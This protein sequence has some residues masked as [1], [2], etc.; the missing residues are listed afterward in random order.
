MWLTAAKLR[1][2]TAVEGLCKLTKEC[3]V[4]GI[5]LERDPAGCL[6][7]QRLVACKPWLDKCHAVIAELEASFAV[8][9]FQMHLAARV[10][11]TTSALVLRAMMRRRTAALS[12]KC[13]QLW[14]GYKHHSWLPRWKTYASQRS[15]ALQ[16]WE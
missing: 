9:Q 6:L 4:L 2:D 13:H 14:V 5:E 10:H 1:S 11:F 16:L 8:R 15:C 12:L 3:E 7:A